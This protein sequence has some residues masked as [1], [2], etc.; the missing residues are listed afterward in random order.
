MGLTEKRVGKK[1][2]RST[3]GD[4]P[5]IRIEDEIK[6]YADAAVETDPVPDDQNAK[7]SSSHHTDIPAE[8]PPAYTREAPNVQQILENAHPRELLN[9]GVRDMD[10]AYEELVQQA[11]MRCSVFEAEMIRQAAERRKM[12][13]A[14]TGS[15]R[16]RRRLR[17]LATGADPAMAGGMDKSVTV[18]LTKGYTVSMNHFVFGAGVAGAALAGKF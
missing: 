10:P 9:P 8:V 3:D 12:G 5:S 15:M 14:E 17:E 18:Y 1:T 6:E 11:G 2:V 16:R 13:S 7:A 4:P